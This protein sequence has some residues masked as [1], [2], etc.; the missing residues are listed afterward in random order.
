MRKQKV[1]QEYVDVV[2]DLA[3]KWGKKSEGQTWRVESVDMCS[4]VLAAADKDGNLAS[5][6]TCVSPRAESFVVPRRADWIATACTSARRG[7]MCSGRSTAVC[8]MDRSKDGAWIGRTQPTVR[9]ACH[10]KSRHRYTCSAK[11][12]CRWEDVDTTNPQSAVEG[13]KH[14][15]FRSS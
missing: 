5:Y 1:I 4:G 11:L 7:T 12:M 8:S 2:L 10:C 6:F 15:P 9:L 14:A 13:M 3:G